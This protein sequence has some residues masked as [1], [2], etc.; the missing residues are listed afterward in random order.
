MGGRVPGPESI[1]M[2]DASPLKKTRGSIFFRLKR[3][4]VK[5]QCSIVSTDF[6]IQLSEEMPDNY[7]TSTVFGYVCD[8]LAV[9]DAI[10]HMDCDKD[11]IAVSAA[12]VETS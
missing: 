8:G 7:R 9:A 11:H 3:D 5:T 10:S 12:G 4:F 2:A 6:C 1:Y